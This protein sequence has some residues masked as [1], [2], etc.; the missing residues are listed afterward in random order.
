MIKL[1]KLINRNSTGWHL[2][3]VENEFF[4]VFLLI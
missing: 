3:H 1:P 2:R 4:K